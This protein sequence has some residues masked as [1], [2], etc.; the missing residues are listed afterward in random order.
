[1]HSLEV[2]RVLNERAAMKGTRQKFDGAV[3][4]NAKTNEQQCSRTFPNP[5][6][7]QHFCG[8]VGAT[9]AGISKQ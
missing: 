9:Y 1:M 6:A 2:I 7:A 5:A 4:R 8:S 3:L